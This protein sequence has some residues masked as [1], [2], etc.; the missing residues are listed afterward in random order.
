MSDRTKHHFPR[1]I[2]RLL[3]MLPVLDSAKTLLSPA[4]D[5]LMAQLPA[6]RHRLGL[7]RLARYAS[8]ARVDPAG[9]NDS[10]IDQFIGGVRRASLHHNPNVLHRK[11]ATIWNDVVSLVPDAK[12]S[13]V[14]K[15]SFRGPLKRIAWDALTEDFRSDVDKY[16]TWCAGADPFAEDA[17]P[18]H[19]RPRS[20]KL[21]RNQIHAAVTALTESGVAP[22]SIN[23]LGDLI[24]LDHFRRILR[25]RNEAVGG[26]ANG[27]NRDLAEALVQI[28]REWVKADATTLAEL[29][30]LT[31]KVP[32]VARG[33]TA[34]NRRAV[35][36]FDDPAVAA[37]LHDLP[38]QLW[39][40]VKRD[41][42][43]NFRTLAKAQAALGIAMLPFIPLRPHNLHGLTF[44][45]HVFLRDRIRSTSSLEIAADE[46]KNNETTLTFHIP[47]QVAKMLIEYR[48]RIAPKVIGRRPERIFVRADGTPKSQAM[49]ALLIKNTLRKRAG[50]ILTR[51][52]SG[53][54]ARKPFS[55]TSLAHTKRCA[56]CSDTKLSKRRQDSTAEC[57][58]ATPACITNGSSMKR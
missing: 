57:E 20:I 33:L 49:V 43:P 30:R 42:K 32:M 40:E 53:T 1:E 14:T 19:L 47:P 12:L 8:A 58:R 25:R 15:P 27:F 24:H 48:A 4:W 38:S 56:S 34:K 35:N 31:F 29:N 5:A 36:Q 37:R 10:V 45:E 26:N 44:D 39:R 7:L 51:I 2:P 52:S 13:P 28:G 50:I 55:T 3:A 21:R 41:Q 18:R 54:S 16:L 22:G 9:V 46:V 17:R 11:V 6:K 23:C